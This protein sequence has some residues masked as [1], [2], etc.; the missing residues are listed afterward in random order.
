MHPTQYSSHAARL[1]RAAAALPRSL[2]NL[3]IF[4]RYCRLLP[5]ALRSARRSRSVDGKTETSRLNRCMFSLAT[6]ISSISR[7]V[8][9]VAL[10]AWPPALPLRSTTS[11]MERMY[12]FGALFCFGLAVW[13]DA[14]TFGPLRHAARLAFFETEA[15]MTSM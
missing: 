11:C 15:L 1:G 9:P 8:S 4:S 12:G 14:A 3:D 7:R 6:S 13:A 2:A 5:K 10:A